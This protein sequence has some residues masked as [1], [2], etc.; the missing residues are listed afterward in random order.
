MPR[1]TGYGYPGAN[2]YAGGMLLRS[3][4]YGPRANNRIAQSYGGFRKTAIQT[5]VNARSQKRRKVTFKSK[6]V[7][8]EPTKHYNANTLN[9]LSHDTMLT[10]CPTSG[11]VQGTGTG[12]RI[13]SQVELMALKIKG[14]FQTTAVSSAFQY[15]I[16][17]GYSGEE[18][19]GLGSVFGVGLTT[20]EV[21]L[22]LT[23]QWVANGIINPKAFTSLYDQTID[24][25]S[26][27]ATTAD[28]NG[29]SF[30]VPLNKTFPYQA[31]TSAFGKDKNL[32]VLI[33]GEVNGG[34]AGVTASG[35]ASFS[36][37]LI[38]K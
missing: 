28:L 18:Y 17:V 8:L 31:D 24:I 3:A 21:F 23:A 1:D 36:F 20:A 37:D 12:N 38:Y 19:A 14:Y 32:Y 34:V 11:I 29:V 35:V 22:P 25:N 15:R 9:A 4:M 27:V 30:T 7:N 2:R 10:T 26:L 33:V 5:S 13:G 6:V 16:I